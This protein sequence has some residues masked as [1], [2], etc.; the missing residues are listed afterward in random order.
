MARVGRLG[1]TGRIGKNVFNDTMTKTITCW[2]KNAMVSTWTLSV[3]VRS[4][5][6]HTCNLLKICLVNLLSLSL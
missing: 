5:N 4:S 1:H 3:W 6:F 2:K